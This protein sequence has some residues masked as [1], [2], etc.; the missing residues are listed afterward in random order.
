MNACLNKIAERLPPSKEESLDLSG[1]IF[2][3]LA[4]SQ[5]QV[6][7]AG[8][9]LGSEICDL[10]KSIQ[11]KKIAATVKTGQ[12]VHFLL[13]AFPAKSPNPQKTHSD[14]PDYGEFLALKHLSKICKDIGNIYSGGARITICSDGHVFGDLVQVEDDVVN[15]Y[16][17]CLGAM[18]RDFDL[19]RLSVF[20]M[21][22]HFGGLSFSTMR[23]EL[24][25]SYGRTVEEI[26]Q[27]VLGSASEKQLF[28]GIH[29]FLFEDMLVLQSN[30][31]RNAARQKSKIMAYE[32][33][34][35][36]HAWSGLVERKF[37]D[38]V[39]LSIHPQLP[40]SAKFGV[41]LLPRTGRVQGL[42]PALDHPLDYAMAE[43]R[44]PW[45]GVALEND[46]G[47]SI[48][49][50]SEALALGAKEVICE[51]GYVYFKL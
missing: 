48:V 8:M 20:N 13:P 41:K 2:Q 35:R 27:D 14:E 29:R 43:W 28:N 38:A 6:R 17:H 22:D 25:A 24:V 46:H 26:R 34:L 5:N 23:S 32:V 44:T 21:Q 40:H 42:D 47:F 45:H 51:R 10:G 4:R 3:I 1:Q 30:L 50:K 37:P 39:R 19:D 33:I 16:G 9:E 7:P 18:I 12:A 49:K 36:S 15:R 31:S 11:L